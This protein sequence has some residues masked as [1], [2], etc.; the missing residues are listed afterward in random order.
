MAITAQEFADV[1]NAV[2]LY[3]TLA[4]VATALGISRKT[5]KNRAGIMRR[6]VGAPTLAS[7]A[8]LGSP[9]AAPAQ[10]MNQEL[11]EPTYHQNPAMGVKRFILTAAQD[12]TNIHAGFWRNLKAYADWLDAKIMVAGFTYSKAH[13]GNAQR[14]FGSKGKENEIY[15]TWHPEVTPYLVNNRVEL[16]DMIRFCGEMNTLPTAVSPLSGFET[17]TGKKWGIFPHTKVQLKSV[18]TAKNELSKQIMTTGAVTLPN[19]VMK[20]EGIKASFHH[21]IG[22]V[23]VE[24]CADGAFFCRHLLADEDGSFYDLDIFVQNGKLTDRHR[25][26]ALVYGDIH[27]E[28]LDPDVALATWGYDVE[29]RAKVI[30]GRS[31][32]LADRLLPR[33]QFFHDLAD[34]SARNHHSINDPHFLFR[35]H[36][37]EQSNVEEALTGCAEFLE[38]TRLEDSLSVVVRSNHNDAL[39]TWLKNAAYDYRKDPENAIFYLETQLRYYKWLAGEAS[40]PP[41]F[42]IVLKERADIDDVLFLGEDESFLICGNIECGNHGDRGA[43]GARGSVRQFTKAGPRSNTAHTH[44]PEIIDG[45]YCAGVSG[46]LDMGYNRGMS[47]WAQAHIVTYTNGKRAILTYMGGRFH[48]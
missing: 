33:H 44:S 21:M 27:H 30:S 48:A 3:P 20:K 14:K 46:K 37:N 31:Q 38:E 6:T 18:A 47:S 39:T 12:S 34:F 26:E 43:N 35:T 28:K 25:A 1:Y 7:R 16:G 10:F 42:E 24:L 9:S 45:A 32:T 2:D 40:D 5:V 13:H 17:Y 23:L 36:Q 11:P 8:T 4:D 15:R 41:I 29:E 19:Y 22:A